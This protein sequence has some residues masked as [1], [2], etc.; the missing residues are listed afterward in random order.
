MYKN[1]DVLLSIFSEKMKD[2][3]ELLADLKANNKIPV[4]KYKSSRTG[5]TVTVAQVREMFWILFSD[6]SRARV[7]GRIFGNGNV[8]LFKIKLF[9]EMVLNVAAFIVNSTEFTIYNAGLFRIYQC[10]AIC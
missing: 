3:F 4:V 8:D 9:N 5:L 7:D 10:V 6:L 2:N 1:C